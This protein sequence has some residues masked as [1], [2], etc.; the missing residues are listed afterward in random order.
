[1]RKVQFNPRNAILIIL[2]LLVAVIIFLLVTRDPTD[3]SVPDKIVQVSGN[4][5]IM[6]GKHV[7]TGLIDDEGLNL[8]IAHCTG[9][10]SAKLVTQNRFNEDGWIRV[11][12]WMQETQN[13]WDLGESETTIVQYLSKHYAPEFSGRR[14]P[15]TDIEWY[16]LKEE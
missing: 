2:T 15:L 9:C 7:V 1:M 4:Q 12:R 11:I 8:V 6:D 5:E 16:E 3:E 10:H 14:V 13:L